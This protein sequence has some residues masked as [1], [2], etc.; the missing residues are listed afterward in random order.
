MALGGIARVSS[1]K[2]VMRYERGEGI[3]TITSF[4]ECDDLTQLGYGNHIVDI[5]QS[6]VNVG[7][8]TIDAAFKNRIF[9]SW[10][11]EQDNEDPK[12]KNACSIFI[13]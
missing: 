7:Y 4:K 5:G 3:I 6:T 13:Y 1:P 10:D 11:I 2:A 8:F 12:N 9:T